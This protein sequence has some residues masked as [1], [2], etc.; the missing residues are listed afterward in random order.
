MPAVSLAIQPVPPSPAMGLARP[1]LPSSRRAYLSVAFWRLVR[2][3]PFCRCPVREL[4]LPQLAPE[5][6]CALHRR[7]P[8]A[9]RASA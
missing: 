6:R 8:G 7:P 1:Q 2:S 4:V 5:G 9:V 3:I